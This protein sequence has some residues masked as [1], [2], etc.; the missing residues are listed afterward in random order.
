MRGDAT[1]R[2]TDEWRGAQTRMGLVAGAAWPV[3]VRTGNL[4]LLPTRPTGRASDVAVSVIEPR[5]AY[6]SDDS[7]Y[8]LSDP[9]KLAGSHVEKGAENGSRMSVTRQSA[10]T[11]ETTVGH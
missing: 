11:R 4:T 5:G 8:L 1:T 3:S 9:K 7:S 10:K 2:T 6:A